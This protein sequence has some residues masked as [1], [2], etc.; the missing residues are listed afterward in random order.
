MRD[1]HIINIRVMT[2]SDI[3]FG[4]QL[5]TEI[6]D[7]GYKKEDIKRLLYYEPNGCFVAEKRGQKI[8]IVTTTIYGKI[9]H[10]GTLIVLPAYRGYGIGTALMEHALN[11]LENCGVETIK[12]DAVTKAIP[13]YERLGF[14]KIFLSL[15]FN[16]FGKIGS[17]SK[18]TRMKKH[19]LSDVA[20]LDQ[21][22]SG[23]QRKIVLNSLYNATPDLCFLYRENNRLLGFIMTRKSINQYK[24][25][26]WICDPDYEGVSEKLLKKV[27]NQANN[28][29]LWVG[30]PGG[31]KKAVVILKKNGFKQRTS[32]MRM[33]RGEEHTS[34]DILGIFGI[35]SPEKG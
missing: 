25:G 16:G 13:L 34:E 26:P 15:R 10:L 29:L 32:S 18:V 22:Y 19:D 14:Q 17:D 28:N 30:V 2:H 31:N 33:V 24:I 35:G 6:E 11:H 3:E 27:L 5:A 4:Y 23:L 12:L 7:W 20:A 1:Q 9:A 8:G 21:Q